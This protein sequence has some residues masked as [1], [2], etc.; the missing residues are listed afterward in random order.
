MPTATKKITTINRITP[1]TPA[2]IQISETCPSFDKMEPP[3]APGGGGAAGRCAATGGA[4]VG[5]GVAAAVGAALA[6]GAGVVPPAPAFGSLQAIPLAGSVAPA[7]QKLAEALALA[8]VAVIVPQY[9][10]ETSKVQKPVNVPV[11]SVVPLVGAILTPSPTASV[12]AS[13][14]PKPDAVTL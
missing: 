3:D 10:R 1:T 11:A 9:F 7:T 8:V 2:L 5:T 6:V 12:I 4:V 13:F 14:A